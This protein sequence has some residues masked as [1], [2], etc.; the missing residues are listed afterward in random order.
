M[1]VSVLRFITFKSVILAS[2]MSALIC[3]GASAAVVFDNLA[4][5]PGNGNSNWESDGVFGAQLFTLSSGTVLNGASF[6][7]LSPGPPS[8]PT[9]TSVQWMIL[10][11]NG[12]GGLPG[13]L[14][15]SGSSAITGQV[16]LG[17]WTFGA[18][19][20]VWKESLGL[21]DVTLGPGSYYVAL[22]DVYT[23]GPTNYLAQGQ[24]NTNSAANSQDGG[25]T[26]GSEY[27]FMPSISVSLT[28][29]DVTAAVP[30]PSTWAM[31]LLGFVGIGAMT[32]RRRK[33][34]MLAA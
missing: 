1:G 23:G 11:A 30:E 20:S 4:S 15:A 16:D 25:A 7:E 33:S 14:L 32:Y 34:S 19:L 5:Q 12:S 2:A 26:W 29:E 22:H 27:G 10:A 31:M 21:P 8:S 24:S 18:S 28:S 6:I 3:T 17:T 13:T 9:I